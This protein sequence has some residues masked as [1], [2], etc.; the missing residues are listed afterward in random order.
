MRY[1]IVILRPCPPYICVRMFD[2]FPDVWNVH[3]GAQDTQLDE[4]LQIVYNINIPTL[5]DIL[6]CL[7]IALN[8][9]RKRSPTLRTLD[10]CVNELADA[11]S[12]CGINHISVLLYP[13]VGSVHTGY[14]KHRFHGAKRLFQPASVVVIARCRFPSV[15]FSFALV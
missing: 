6:L 10:T 15:S 3:S 2:V 4:K 13:L 8:H 1:Y 9:G 12:F 14:K 11:G 7:P 5:V